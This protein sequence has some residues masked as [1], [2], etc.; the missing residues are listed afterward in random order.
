M[1]FEVARFLQGWEG[2]GILPPLTPRVC[3]LPSHTYTES[4]HKLWE[5]TLSS[6]RAANMH[7]GTSHQQLQAMRKRRM[8][9]GT[10]WYLSHLLPQCNVHSIPHNPSSFVVAILLCSPLLSNRG[11]NLPLVPFREQMRVHSADALLINASSVTT[12]T[13]KGSFV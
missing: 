3:P 1:Q 9:N 5:D 4:C 6:L 12:G 2:W 13:L 8:P 10:S 11:Q 7:L